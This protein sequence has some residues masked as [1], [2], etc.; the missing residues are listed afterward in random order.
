MDP[1]TEAKASGSSSE[2]DWWKLEAGS[3]KHFVIDFSNITSWPA[4][5]FDKGLEVA[6]AHF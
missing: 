1:G 2:P 5:V 6:K 4:K 3:T